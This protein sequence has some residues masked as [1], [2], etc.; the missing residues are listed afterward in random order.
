MSTKKNIKV[1]HVYKTAMPESYGGVE[2]FIDTLCKTGA[3]LGIQNTVLSLSRTP[4]DAPLDMDG[5]TVHQVR[6]DLFLASTGFSISAF[7]KFS[8]LAKQTDVIHYHFPNP[9]ADMLHMVCSPKKPSVLTYH[10]DIIKQKKLL[11]I[12]QPL[13]RRFLNAVDHIVSTSPNYFVTSDV[14][15]AY[16]HKVSIIP[17]GIDPR[18]CENLDEERLAYWR[19]RLKAP[20]FYLLGP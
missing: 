14:L 10:S 13:K 6:Q 16:A 3:S 4:A 20:F 5:Y 11:H 8:K 2:S 9:F 1:L 19:T 12:Y 15:Q 18:F 7:G 17:V